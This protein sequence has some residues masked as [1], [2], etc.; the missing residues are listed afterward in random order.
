MKLRSASAWI[1]WMGNI[2]FSSF[3]RLET[4]IGK[5]PL[6][7]SRT[8]RSSVGGRPWLGYTR[9]HQ[10]R[11][12]RY[13]WCICIFFW[14]RSRGCRGPSRMA[15]T[16]CTCHVTRPWQRPERSRKT[17]ILRIYFSGNQRQLKSREQQLVHKCRNFCQNS[18]LF[19]NLCPKFMFS[20][21][22]AGGDLLGGEE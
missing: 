13:F 7:C 14:G 9:H 10:N 16:S 21:R 17:L 18:S 12:K 2:L 22:V 1:A 19:D 5:S 3:C 8:Q 15:R 20:G 11:N 6:V 4:C